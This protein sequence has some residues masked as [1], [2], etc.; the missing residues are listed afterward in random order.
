MRTTRLIAACAA[1]LVAAPVAAQQR[2]DLNAFRRLV[3]VSSPAVAP[4]GRSVAFIVRRPDFGR[5]RYTMTLM[6]ADVATGTS[7]PLPFAG[8]G[9]SDLHWSPDG[10]S[11][12]FLA[13][14][15]AGEGRQLWVLPVS[16]GEAKRLTSAPVGVQSYA[17]RPDGGAIAFV[18]R[19]T[20]PQDTGE[21]K[22]R[23]AFEVGN[24]DM[25]R[26][27]PPEPPSHI[28]VM[29]VPGGEARRL[30]SGKWTVEYFLPPGPEM[31]G[32]SWSP[33]GRSIAFV[34]MPTTET[35]SGDSST[36]AVLDVESG[37]LRALTGAATLE[38]G[39][40]FSP[41]GRF[42]AYRHPRAGDDGEPGAATGGGRHSVLEA[43]VAPAS[44]GPGRVVSRPLDRNL[45]SAEWLPDGRSLLVGGNTGTT[46]GF[47]IQPL[48]GAARPLPLGDLVVTGG[49]GGG[50]GISVAR[51]G[52][53]ALTATT[54]TRPSELYFMTSPMA[55]PRRLTDLN[56]EVAAFALGRTE[57]ITWSGPDG[58]TEDGVVTYPPDFNPGR[59]YPLVLN[60]HGGPR[61][62]STT[63]FDP[64]V[65]A[66]ASE[67]WI[68]F[69]PNYRGS[70]NLGERY[71]AAI[72][73]DAGKGPGQDVMAG[74]AE[75][76]KR[77]YVDPTRTAVTGWSYGGFMTT[78]LIGSYPG[79]W[80]AA[81]AGA[82][83][84][85]WEDT[86]NLSDLNVNVRYFFGGSPWTGGRQQ[87]YREQSPIT[88]VA[89]VH[90][91]TLIMS[92]T[93]DYRVPPT[94]AYAL[95][96]ALRDNGVETR[97]V[98]YPGAV[99]FPGSPVIMQ[100]IYSRW[101]GWVRDHLGA[102]KAAPAH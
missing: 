87:A 84:T 47:W 74:V 73:N 75:L 36:V 51:T 62:A 89:Q 56:A 41:D 82:P 99:H 97:F 53:I 86:Y 102:T 52:A 81:V 9:A 34:R 28:W 78:W 14:A 13:N 16:G 92:S 33:D 85:S 96:R 69:Q 37:A 24:N 32:L 79:E 100:D 67:G 65:Q 54:S 57:A 88:Y 2:F 10:R 40:R 20:V 59:K 63:S 70:D 21:A 18:T 93:R 23:K 25:F 46:A 39:A 50:Y 72:V 12:A 6:L 61:Q 98:A 42:I 91:P 22:F 17:W 49:G 1:I 101:I 48:E 44:G 11:L 5:N 55:T 76:R 68:V 3:G 80:Q 19:D 4:D 8:Q 43:Y 38:V 58:F 90:T 15:G 60:I 30:T 27:A 31:S 83:V 29:S 7:R 95:F 45:R 94:Q 35:G 77:P 71:M 66:M 26:E 64:F